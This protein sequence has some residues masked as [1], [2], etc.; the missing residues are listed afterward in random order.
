MLSPSVVRRSG[1]AAKTVNLME[2]PRRLQ[3]LQQPLNIGTVLLPNRFAMAPMTTNFATEQGLVTQQLVD[4]LEARARGG[5]GLVITENLGV[6][7]SG[8]VMPRMAMADR[9]ECIDG[10]TRLARGIQ[11]YGARAFAQISHCGRQ[12]RS[13]FTGQPLRAP[14]AIACPVNRELPQALSGDEA[15]QAIQW[16]VDAAYRV[17]QAGF[18][19]VEL[20]G[21]HGYLIAG[22]LSAYSNQRQDDYGGT[23]EKRARFLLQIVRGIK[24][25]CRLALTV[26]ISADELVPQ[27]NT[28]TETAQLA[29]WLQD[30]GVDA[31]S[32]SVGVYES[33][34]AMSMVAGETPGQW[35]PL[36]AAIKQHVSIPVMGVG[37]IH[38]AALAEQAI[39]AGWCDLPLFGRS[40]IADAD[41][42]RKALAGQAHTTLL[43]LACNVCLGR[44]ARPETICPMSP[45][46]G[47]QAWFD[48]V[49]CTPSH[50]PRRI[51]VVGTGLI[52]LTAAW[53]A[54]RQ[55]HQV[56][57]VD[58][59]PAGGLQG[60]RARVPQQASYTRALAAARW[61]A[62][63]AGVQWQSSLDQLPAGDEY[64]VERA[65]LAS[66]SPQTLQGI[67]AM[68]LQSMGGHLPA[69]IHVD[70]DLAL[71]AH[72]GY[73][74]L[75][76]RHFAEL[77]VPV[78]QDGL[79]TETL[80]D[81]DNS[82]P[83]SDFGI[84]PARVTRWIE[85][86]YEPDRMTLRLNEF[87][88]QLVQSENSS[89]LRRA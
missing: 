46:V 68:V 24:A 89:P 43:C 21:A 82:R 80:A 70:K 32:V 55:G 42:P 66:R 30:A 63:S 33:F 51:T 1:K 52:A 8:R 83:A 84:D 49:L 38:E 19:G 40:A 12:S 4:H 39:R 22:F 13:K 14:S 44:S 27:G 67:E 62:Q 10:L 20:H 50:Q 23:L 69:S 76:R 29:S 6:H 17:E 64:W 28:L 57:V 65:A 78:V 45:Q 41:L 60:Q 56:S 79:A 15:H 3:A 73:R 54:A 74:A 7:A 81:E 5:F 37:R 36:A 25:R 35:L 53:V 47:R 58:A 77:G 34:N 88:A 87:L 59:Q 86:C 11:N 75:Y 72:P 2:A 16:F 26:R 61:R 85:D 71:D 48:Q 18:D 31:L 9:D